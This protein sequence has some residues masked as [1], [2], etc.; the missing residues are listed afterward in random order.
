[1]VISCFPFPWA[2]G[3]LTAAGT[4]IFLLIL[5]VQYYTSLREDFEGTSYIVTLAIVRDFL[6][7]GAAAEVLIF[8]K[9]AVAKIKKEMFV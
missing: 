7:I 6:F 5:E 8:Y 2:W 3:A 4:A 1:M 9:N